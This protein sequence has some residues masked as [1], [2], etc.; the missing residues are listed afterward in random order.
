MA[1]DELLD[2]VAQAEAW[3]FVKVCESQQS[4]VSSAVEYSMRVPDLLA[5][6]TFRIG[7]LQSMHSRQ[8][9]G[10]YIRCM[11]LNGQY[12]YL[13]GAHGTQIM[14]LLSG[15]HMYTGTLMFIR[16]REAKKS[17]SNQ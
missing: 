11:H 15:Q 1:T 8:G 6:N 13:I 12:E 4:H 5:S 2:L 3:R 9:S 17:K 14:M 7:E 16:G 10:S